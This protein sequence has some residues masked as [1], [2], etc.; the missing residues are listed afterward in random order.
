VSVSR[1]QK[2]VGRSVLAGVGL[3]DIEVRR[4]PSGIP[5]LEP[6]TAAVGALRRC[7]GAAPVP[8]LSHGGDLAAAT[9][10]P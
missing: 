9:V 8:S 7:G 4:G 5:G 6:G 1:I 3:S 10:V 2:G